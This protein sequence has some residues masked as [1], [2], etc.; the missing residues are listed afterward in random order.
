MLVNWGTAA[1]ITQVTPRG[2]VKFRLQL[3]D[4]TYRAIRADGWTGEPLGPPLVLARRRGP[5]VRVWASW[6]GA[7]RVRSW[8]VLAGDSADAL[9]PTGPRHAFADLETQMRV[10]ARGSYAAVEALDAAGTVLGRSDAVR[11]QG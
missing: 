2:R 6:N 9:H 5:H 4:W 10:R 7:T 1:R 3:R 8:R 11:V